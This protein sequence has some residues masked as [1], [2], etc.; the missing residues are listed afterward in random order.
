SATQPRATKRM[1]L[2]YPR[3]ENLQAYVSEYFIVVVRLCH[4]LLK[5]TQMSTIRQV[6]STLSDSDTNAFQ[7]ELD[8][9]ANSIKEEIISL[10]AST[11]EEE[12][13]ENSL[14]R[15][16]Y[17]KLSISALHQQKLAT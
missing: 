10:M 17:N 3:S 9:W 7:S 14:F 2:L 8:G 1:A 5:F 15:I 6:A 11:V 13:Q 16:L 4:R 12:A